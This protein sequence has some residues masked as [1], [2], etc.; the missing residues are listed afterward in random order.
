M[1]VTTRPAIATATSNPLSVNSHPRMI[2]MACQKLKL[3]RAAP[4][5][6]TTRMPMVTPL[7]G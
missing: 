6:V 7:H 4:V 1:M 3:E 5:L 2:P